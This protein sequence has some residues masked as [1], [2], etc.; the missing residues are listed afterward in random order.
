MTTTTTVLSH[1]CMFKLTGDS[2]AI[3]VQQ[4]TPRGRVPDLHS[5]RRISVG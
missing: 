5:L 1:L 2:V 4:Q 3:T